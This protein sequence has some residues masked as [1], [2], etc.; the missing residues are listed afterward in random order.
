MCGLFLVLERARPVALARA[1]RA[2]E[3]LRHRGPDGI[4]QREFNWTLQ[5]SDGPV[6]VSGYMGHTRLAI[7]DP[8]ARSDQPF[9]RGRH[10]LVYNG[11][12]YNFRALRAD[13][14]RGGAHFDTDGDT[15]VLLSLLAHEGIEGLNRANGMWGLC[16]LDQTQG[17]V[18]ATRDRYGKK[19]LFW[20]Q[21]EQRLCMA[22][23]IGP[24][25]T[26]LGQSPRFV[27]RDLDNY[28]HGGWCFPHADGA[29]HLQGI[30]QVAAGTALV[31]N[32]AQWSRAVQTWYDLPTHVARGNKD[33]QQLGAL[34]QDAVCA[35]LVADR[36]VG[37]LLSGG[38]DS[39]L[40]LSVLAQQG[41]TEQVTCFTGDAGKSDDARYARA[42]IEQLGMQSVNL[43]LEYGSAGMESFLQVCR[44]QE[45]PFPFIGNALAMPQL[46]AHIAEYNVPV[47]LD[48]TGGDEIFAGYWDRYF[49]FAAAQAL[50][51]GD[52][53]WRAQVLQANADDPRTLAIAE[54]AFAWCE[55]RDTLSP[56]APTVRRES[57]DPADMDQFVAA[58]VAAA[59]GCD[60]L[61]RFSGDLTQALVLDAGAGRLHEWL[62]QN[63]RNAM[64]SGIENRSPLLDY[65][66]A[67]YIGSGYARKF[68]GPWNKH[69][70]RS[71]FPLALPTQWRRDKQGFRWV[72]HRFLRQNRDQV[73]QLIAASTILPER[74]DV[75]RLLDAARRDERY[76]GCSLLHR[77]LCIAGLE[78]TCGI[79]GIASSPAATA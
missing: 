55:Q 28:L 37:L 67:P 18:T 14:A 27:A 49:R 43:P 15:E 59:P 21:D 7:L 42:C 78:Q 76:L 34:L 66:L 10:T 5:G 13:L 73:L 3:A 64:M 68:V 40:I 74:I 70:L 29:T 4:G 33:P 11:E 51:A 72:Y 61:T 24:I 25:L 71:L 1:R 6:A 12:I 22:S 2:T 57:D 69:E 8:L 32:L 54:Q 77:S 41:L 36:R 44:A 47:V 65:R 9:Q 63:D 31:F 45:K 35:R 48:G 39:S 16:L 79:N 23:E 60:P 26:Y 46:Y 17:T 38:V 53:Q 62:W 20:Y 52:E 50:A 75:G 58:S 56:A 30:H 19:P